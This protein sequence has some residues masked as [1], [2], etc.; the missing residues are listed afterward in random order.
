MLKYDFTELPWNSENKKKDE[1]ISQ[2]SMTWQSYP[3]TWLE[4]QMIFQSLAGK[5]P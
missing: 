4:N 1:L 5:I 3:W 2:E